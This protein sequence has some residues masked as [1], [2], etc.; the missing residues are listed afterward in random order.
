[1]VE[2]GWMEWKNYVLNMLEKLENRIDNIEKDSV[3]TKIE[4]TKIL[5]KSKVYGALAGFA[6][7]ALITLIIGIIIELVKSGILL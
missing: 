4:I 2:N 7:S 6:G 3:N 1:M 5:T